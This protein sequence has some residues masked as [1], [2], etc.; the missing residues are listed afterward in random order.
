MEPSNT[1]RVSDVEE[2]V[3]QGL[4]A[5][6]AGDVERAVRLFRQAGDA[7]P[8]LPVP[9]LLLAAELAQAGDAG[10]AEAAYASAILIAPDL[11]IARFQ[12]GLL[13][14]TSGRVPVALL[15]WSPLLDRPAD[16]PL[17]RYVAG[18][19]ALASDDR[20]LALRCIQ[21][22]LE[23]TDSNAPLKADMQ[24]VLARIEA[25]QAVPA[26]PPNGDAVHV[27]LSNY[28]RQGRMH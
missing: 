17:Q 15:T 25:I 18:F 13:Q 2:L 4:E 9:R 23:R 26:E 8:D 19:H 6:R 16:E 3:R 5:S 10:A 11:D 24:M 22:G 21:E 14:F 27:L 20:E 28:K 1:G 7:R 12:L